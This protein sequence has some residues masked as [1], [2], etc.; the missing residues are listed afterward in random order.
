MRWSS[1]TKVCTCPITFWFG[2]VEGLP[3]RGSL[4]TI[5]QPSLKRLYHFFSLDVLM[6]SSPKA[7]WIWRMVSTCVSSL[8]QY[9]CPCCSVILQ[10]TGIRKALTT[11]PYSPV[12]N[13]C[14]LRAEKH[15]RMWTNV[16]SIFLPKEASRTSL[17]YAGKKKVRYFWNATHT[18]AVTPQWDGIPCKATLW[19][20][21]QYLVGR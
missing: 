18:L 12:S 13:W 7:S 8:M 3:E 16:P 1:M 4:S 9:R 10:L 17:V 5:V 2:L 6:A 19:C 20:I 11:R 14:F 21:P 15:S